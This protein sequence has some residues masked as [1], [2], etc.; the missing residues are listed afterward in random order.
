MARIELL[1]TA[2]LRI[3][4]MKAAR[5]LTERIGEFDRLLLPYP[6]EME[7]HL[8]SL[9]SRRLSYHEA[10][11]GI[12]ASQLVPEPSGAWE[13]TAE[14][15][16][17]ALPDLRGAQHGLLVICVGDRGDEYAAMEASV[18]IACLTLNAMITGRVDHERW[19]EA[20]MASLERVR[21]AAKNMERRILVKAAGDIACV[22]GLGSRPIKQALVD[23]GHH[24]KI[25]FVDEFYHFTPISILER[26]LAMGP[27]DDLSL[28]ALIRGHLEYVKDYI[29][30]HGSRDGAHYE[31]TYD[32]A[33]WLRWGLDRDEIKYLDCFTQT[34]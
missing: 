1:L 28:E 30:R 20:V 5:L 4:S 22:V 15:I 25:S 31:W 11:R 23:A 26:R 6:E 34:S 7:G 14:P 12:I 13:Y 32:K 3:S 21:L 27:V 8:D 19:R 2:N 16:L 17:R 24:V 9:A 18:A 33:A 29:Y 10:V